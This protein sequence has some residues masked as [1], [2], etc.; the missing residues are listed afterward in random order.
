MVVMRRQN[1]AGNPKIFLPLGV[2][3]GI[4]LELCLNPGKIIL[5]P[6]P[7]SVTWRVPCVRLF[8]S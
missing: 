3:G 6:Y 4:N 2:N 8:L 7:A 5:L 1:S